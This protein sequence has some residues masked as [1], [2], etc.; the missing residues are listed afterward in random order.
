MYAY[1]KLQSFQELQNLAKNL[2][3]VA[4]QLLIFRA[5]ESRLSAGGVGP[6]AGDQENPQRFIVAEED[7]L[8]SISIAVGRV[9]RSFKLAVR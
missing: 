3:V 2:T 9:L 5:T 6:N 4:R 7:V 8:R 1:S